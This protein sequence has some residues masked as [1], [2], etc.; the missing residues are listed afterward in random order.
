MGRANRQALDQKGHP[1]PR[2][3]WDPQD[4]FKF[5][6]QKQKYQCNPGDKGQFRGA[7]HSG[8][9]TQNWRASMEKGTLGIWARISLTIH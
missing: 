4:A 7:H 9:G 5:D 1:L 2:L 8:K 3:A 6:G